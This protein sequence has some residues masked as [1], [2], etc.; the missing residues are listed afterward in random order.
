MIGDVLQ[1][2]LFCH[3]D[4]NARLAASLAAGSTGALIFLSSCSV[5]PK[6]ETLEVY[7]LPA[8]A[9]NRSAQENNR[10]WA[11]HIATPRSSQIT[12]SVRVLVLQQDNQIS[13]Y[14]GV[15]WSDPAPILVRDR[16]INAFRADGGLRSVSSNNKLSSDLELDGDLGAFQ[17]EYTNG[18]ASVN[19][20]FYAILVQPARNSIV[21]TR[22]FEVRQ[23]AEGKDIREVMAAFGRAT[24][25][26]A[27]EIIDWTLQHGP[28]P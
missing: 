5:L 12:D 18:I 1:A 8:S 3:P 11:L 21:A 22:S 15:R 14:K 27:S 20:R 13:A 16:L 7:Q 25:T 4:W 6:T 10:P 19:I 17:M 24:D 28:G 9:I 2:H 26:L 23:S